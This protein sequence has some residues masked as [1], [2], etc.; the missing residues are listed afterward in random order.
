MI[1]RLCVR[2]RRLRN[3]LRTRAAFACVLLGFG[4][5][6]SLAPRVFVVNS[7]PGRI[8]PSE[9][10][11]AAW[12][13]PESTDRP[14]PCTPTAAA[15][16]A[17]FA[18]EPIPEWPTGDKG[19]GP[20]I[21][22]AKLLQGQDAGPINEYLLGARPVRRVGST[23]EVHY[24]DHDF[25]EAALIPLL[26]LA[27]ERLSEDARRHLLDV[28]LVSEGPGPNLKVP[29]TF[30]I[31]YDTENHILMTES[32]RY[33]KNQWLCRHGETDAKYDNQANGMTDWL[34]A[35]L[36]ALR[37]HGFYEFNSIPYE[38]YALL[39]LL[40]LEAFAE[41]PEVAAAARAVL[42]EHAEEASLRVF[43]DRQ[44]GPF[45]RQLRY[46]GDG[47]LAEHTMPMLMRLW[48]APPEGKTI[49]I[50]HRASQALAGAFLSYRPPKTILERAARKDRRYFAKLGHGLFGSPEIL[51]GGP[52]RLL[53]AGGVW[54]GPWNKV[55]PRPT[56]L[57]VQDGATRIDG[58][59]HLPAEGD[60]RTWNNTG[61]YDGFAVGPGKVHVPS[62][63]KTPKQV[64]RWSVH[65]SS[66]QPPV[67]VAVFEGSG[68]S[69]VWIG[70]GGADP[71]ELLDTVRRGNSEGALRT[72]A[73]TLDGVRLEYD[74]AAPA[75]VWVI[76]RIDGEEVERCHDR[77]P[78]RTVEIGGRKEP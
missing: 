34:L 43:D 68:F 9:N 51:S 56:I 5:L 50:P 45:R 66:T 47:N 62:S 54:R 22:L 1:Q 2:F 70:P 32:S 77:W 40:S 65:V 44:A 33:L 60:S 29:R 46:L 12:R 63:W 18:K 69:A 42:D 7:V 61:V 17:R 37:L 59:L 73:T 8:P 30:G 31:V 58:C 19:A 39:P 26:Y 3:T 52:G 28:L 53:V 72:K 25:C 57:L 4:Q 78:R 64:G 16:V 23:W 6:F 11:L 48:G 24:G 38:G 41:P 15:L 67:P 21:A 74:V 49:A 20:R 76:K 35:H 36:N 27:G 14:N 55:I 13:T 75:G 10:V 71:V